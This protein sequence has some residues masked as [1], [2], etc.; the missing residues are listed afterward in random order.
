MLSP[1]VAENPWMQQALTAAR[2]RSCR[3]FYCE[4]TD[5]ASPSHADLE[6]PLQPHTNSSRYLGAS[7][8]HRLPAARDEDNSLQLDAK[9]SLPTGTNSSPPAEAASNP[10]LGT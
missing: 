8:E 9:R 6:S 7:R 10:P 1:D 3:L 5:S 4:P 2:K